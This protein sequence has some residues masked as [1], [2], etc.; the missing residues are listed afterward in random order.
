MSR[1]SELSRV[2]FCFT[3][4]CAEV[5]SALGLQCVQTDTGPGARPHALSVP[6]RESESV[7]C[8]RCAVADQ[9]CRNTAVFAMLDV[10]HTHGEIAPWPVF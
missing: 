10:K 4:T 3:G 6:L 1:L 2:D 5:L 9:L 7:L 8:V